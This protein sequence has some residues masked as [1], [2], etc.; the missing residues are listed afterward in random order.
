MRDLE[1]AERL[2]RQHLRNVKESTIEVCRKTS[3]VFR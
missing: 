3:E 2:L 1:E